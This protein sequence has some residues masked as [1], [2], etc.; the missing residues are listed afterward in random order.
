MVWPSVRWPSSLV[1]WKMRAAQRA[2]T[3]TRRPRPFTFVW[4]SLVREVEEEE[5]ALGERRWWIL[6]VG[7]VWVFGVGV[8]FSWWCWVDGNGDGDGVWGIVAEGSIVFP[9]AR[10]VGAMRFQL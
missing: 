4:R 8:G 7:A 10:E 6:E 1:S 5:V 3:R 9:W 2:G